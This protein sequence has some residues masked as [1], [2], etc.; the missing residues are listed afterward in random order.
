MEGDKSHSVSEHEAGMLSMFRVLMEE[1]R[2]SDIARAEEQ[3][4]SDLAREEARMQE[5][6]KPEF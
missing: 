2:K 3:R 4:R 6:R 5:E 1:Q